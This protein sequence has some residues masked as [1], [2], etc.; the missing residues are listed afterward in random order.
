MAKLCTFLCTL[1]YAF[2]LLGRT[3]PWC[4]SSVETKGNGEAADLPKAEEGS[5]TMYQQFINQARV[6]QVRRD[7][8]REAAAERTLRSM[9]LDEHVG[10]SFVA[11]AVGPSRMRRAL[12]SLHVHL[13]TA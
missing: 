2:S 10:H 13:A 8:E 9:R 12:R 5:Q 11:P 4:N 7:R 3:P 1:L 6:D